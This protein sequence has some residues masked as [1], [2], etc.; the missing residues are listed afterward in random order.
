MLSVLLE[1]TKEADKKDIGAVLRELN[2]LQRREENI[3][4]FKTQLVKS[5]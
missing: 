5:S 2:I 4:D 1:A 3:E